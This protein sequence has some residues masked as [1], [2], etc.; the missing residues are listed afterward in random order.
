M[1]NNESTLILGAGLSGLGCALELP[2]ARMFEAAREPGGHVRSHVV[3]GVA[4]DEGAHI[5]HAKDPAWQELIFKH[6]GEVE[7]HVT[8]AVLNYW[9]GH[10]I[11]YPA[12]NHLAELPADVRVRALSELVQAQVRHR[13]DRPSHYLDWCLQQYGA[14][15][16]EH[17]YADYTRKYWRVPMEE[18]G[19]DW[20]KGRL[21]P[22]ELDR[23]IAGAVT[24]QEERQ[25]VFSSFHYPARGGFFAFFKP[26]YNGVNVTCGEPAVQVD[27]RRKQ[28]TFASGRKEGYERLVSTMPLTH[29]VGMLN[30]VPASVVEAAS[31]LRHTQLICVNM[32]INQPALSPAH[33]FYVYGQDVQ[34]ARVKVMSNV[35]PRGTPPGCTALQCEIFRRGDES[36]NADELAE[37]TVSDMARLLKFSAS[38]VKAVAPVVVSHAY[39][40]SDL[41]R[42][43]RVAH[44]LEWLEGR[45]VHSLGLFGRW[46]FIWSD[47]AFQGGRN[48]AQ[49][50]A[51]T[52]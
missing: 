6:A 42:A 4:F 34:A 16:T 12:Q 13:D 36:F 11:T 24:R 39:P 48:L 7:H 32:V 26:M 43:D 30:D 2:G 35:A 37:A 49:Q 25:S 8:S 27:T 50:L 5:C 46:K 52:A 28:V 3:G 51:A 23:I 19:T 18:L 29:L 20:L 45:G 44:I 33:W 21:L 1:K 40:I 14:Y 17:F 22:S 9:R 31:G 15:L 10:W 41:G 38:D 47:A